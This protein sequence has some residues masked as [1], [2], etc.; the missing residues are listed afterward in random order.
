MPLTIV[1]LSP[2]KTSVNS[3]L[4]VIKTT[5]QGENKFSETMYIALHKLTAL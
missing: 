5:I 3:V 4:Y 1:R 2:A